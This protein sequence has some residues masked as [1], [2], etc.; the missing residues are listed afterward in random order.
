MLCL[1]WRLAQLMAFRVSLILRKDSGSD[2]MSSLT[3]EKIAKS[4][5]VTDGLHH[6]NLSSA[7]ECR[8]VPRPGLACNVAFNDVQFS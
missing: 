2:C 3:A 7:D 6:L 8:G 5:G 1:L 4:V